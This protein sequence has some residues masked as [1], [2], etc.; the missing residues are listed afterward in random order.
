MCS[1]DEFLG[2]NIFACFCTG[3][4][5]VPYKHTLP[6]SSPFAVKNFS[7]R[8]RYSLSIFLSGH[9]FFPL[10]LHHFQP[11]TDTCTFWRHVSPKLSLHTRQHQNWFNEIPRQL[12]ATSLRRI[13][14]KLLFRGLCHQNF[15]HLFPHRAGAS[16]S[17]LWRWHWLCCKAVLAQ[18]KFAYIQIS[19]HQFTPRGSFRCCVF[20]I[21]ARFCVFSLSVFIPRRNRS[22]A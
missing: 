9:N 16:S 10:T 6:S 20:E 2:A 18:L 12:F 5:L 8:C 13:P 15:S 19:H 1:G 4:T 17:R 11:A 14:G 3:L 21:S 7:N 22:F